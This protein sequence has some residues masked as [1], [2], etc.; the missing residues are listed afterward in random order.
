MKQSIMI[1]GTGGQGVVASGSF[2]SNAL[3]LKDYEVMFSRSYGAEAR[4]GSCRAEIMVSDTIINDL[5]F[6]KT[7]V[8]L[9]LSLPAFKK[10]LPIAKPGSI[11]FVD[12]SVYDRAENVR[13][14][15]EIIKVPARDI[16]Q[17]LGNPIVAN[18]VILGALAKRSEMVRL[19]LLKDAVI[20]NMRESMRG[21]NLKA[22]QMG[23]DSV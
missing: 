11:V 23:Y 20:A 15:V 21:I 4:G 3:F 8:L 14:D 16:A 7:D 9:C 1:S 6:E 17:S 13:T 12:D 18:M 19:D 2:L 10:Y 5:Q 22:I